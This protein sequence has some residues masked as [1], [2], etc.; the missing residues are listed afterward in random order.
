L[1][2]MEKKKKK[3][4][5]K[6]KKKNILFVGPFP[7][8][9]RGGGE[10]AAYSLAKSIKKKGSNVFV[11]SMGKDKFFETYE[12][13]GIKFYRID[14]FYTGRKHR[15]SLFH[16]IRY[17]TV[18]LFNLLMFLSTLY[19][20]I[21]HKINAVHISTFHQMSFSP[22]IAAKLLFRKT[23]ITFHSHELFCFFSSLTPSCG[24]VG[25]GHCGECMLKIQKSPKFLNKSNK[26]AALYKA[27]T[28][29][30]DYLIRFVLF[31]KLKVAQT[32]DHILFPSEYL[33]N[34]YVGHGFDAKKTKV[35]YNFLNDRK[36]DGKSAKDFKRR[37]G[38]KDEKVILFVGNI[39]EF[40]GPEVL[41][42]AFSILKKNLKNNKNTMKSN[43]NIKLMFV[44]YGDLL[45]KLK[46]KASELK[47]NGR[48]VFT[49]WIP[50]D[51]V[52]SAYNLSDIVVIPSLFPETFSFIF[53]E[54]FNASTERPAF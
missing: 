3:I 6:N 23:L 19:L 5:T 32:A 30:A 43:K 11:L 38:I 41:L 46:T 17:F 37:L 42:D 13:S 8:H 7:P 9:Q 51:D 35:I 54:A 1:S 48:V 50:R 29:S 40:K 24:G 22:L 36:A 25:N 27:A 53:L 4:V 14:K 12:D 16:V 39:I 33:R 49:D 28:A 10:N 52:V 44:G 31:L 15:F 2:G 21:R 26:H 34:Y 18:E 20:I 45:D 47:L